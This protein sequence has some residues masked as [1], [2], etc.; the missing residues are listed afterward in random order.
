MEGTAKY[1]INESK[2]GRMEVGRFKQWGIKWNVG[3]EVKVLIKLTE[4]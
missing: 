2:E 4:D 1:Q 3:T